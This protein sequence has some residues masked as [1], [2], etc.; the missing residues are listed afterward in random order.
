MPKHGLPLSRSA[1]SSTNPSGSPPSALS[2]KHIVLLG[3]GHTN[4]HLVRMWRMHALPGA[5]LTCVS[6][7]STVTYSGMLPGVLAGQYPRSRMEIDLVRLCASVGARLII[8]QVHGLDRDNRRLLIHDRPSIPFD[9]LSIGVGSVTSRNRERID[10]TAL[11]I[12]PMQTFLDRIDERLSAL[13]PTAAFRPLRIAIVGAGAGGVEIAFCLPARVRSVVGGQA[14]EIA[15]ISAHND[16]PHGA[17]AN[18]QRLVRRELH[19]R[20]ISLKLN[21]RVVSVS[22][23]QLFFD[24]GRS[25]EADLVIWA[26]GAE[27]APWLTTLGL[28]TDDRGFILTRSTLQ[29]V[30]DDAVFAV[31]D[32]GTIDGESLPK[33]GVYAVR[34]GPV[35]WRNVQRL[36]AGRPLI[37]Y[38]PQRGFLK[39]LNTGDRHAI[40]EYKGRAFYGRW[41]WWLK[42]RIDGRF[43]DMYQAYEPP[44]M[45]DA[46]M[47]DVP[48]ASDPR[49][50]G[51][52]CK[53]GSSILS[54]ALQRLQIPAHPDVLLG[55][56]QPDDAAVLRS[57]DGATVTASVDFFTAPLDDPYLVGRIAA[58]N[59]ASDLFAMGAKPSAALSLAT[60]PIGPPSQQEE[61]LFQLLSGSLREFQAMGAT[62]V[63][64]HTTEGRQVSIGFSLL[65][66]G[67]TE[68]PRVKSALQPGDVLIL[69]KPL[70]TGVLLV[71]LMRAQCPAAAYESMLESMLLSNEAAA[72]IAD[73]FELKAVTDVTGFGLAG[74]LLEMLRASRVAAEL[75]L[76]ALPL[77]PG[78]EAFLTL[79][80]QS[81]LAPANRTS[82]QDMQVDDALRQAGR[83][84]ALFDPQTNGGLL[85]GVA[86]SRAES[87]C[88]RL[89]QSAG[90]DPRIV[91]RV[92]RAEP[93]RPRLSI[94]R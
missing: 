72:R 32:C 47:N 59:S 27:A 87:L 66:L 67:G 71:A 82:E 79:G 85:L 35:L 63:G 51:C 42:N 76:E 41:C 68:P 33:A 37:R 55:L 11:S 58:L 22:E 53:V 38:Q 30:S 16:V 14:P 60:L 29:S 54:Q 81:T 65:A 73:E 5:R 89:Q 56:D 48:D 93:D 57:G 44:M 8:G 61:L 19:R 2:S 24:D 78:A 90:L 36:L 21:H 70:G 64:G 69:T 83:Y 25:A 84:A 86:E 91:A 7:Y 1:L 17:R 94:V 4:A 46:P 92:T 77:L 18:T 62:I 26:T 31:G 20:R 43:M 49:C 12:K 23:G 40:A 28:E 88:K 15:L 3:I 6:N 9:V 10:S 13:A 74:H 80:W 34:Q 50:A 52:G 45:R 75:T 39:L